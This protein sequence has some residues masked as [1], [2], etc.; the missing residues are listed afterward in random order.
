M[1]K[2]MM[3]ALATTLL[4]SADCDILT[5]MADALCVEAAKYCRV[6]ALPPDT[7]Y[8]LAE[9]LAARYRARQYGTSALPQ[10]VSSVKDA[11]QQVSYSTLGGDALT[12]PVGLSHSEMTALDHWRRLF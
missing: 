6:A 8:T 10:T 5:A 9:L 7:T 2:S 3:L 4:G 1:D 12:T 11:D